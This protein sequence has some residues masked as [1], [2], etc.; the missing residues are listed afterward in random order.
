MLLK[1][2]AKHNQIMSLKVK[3]EMRKGLIKQRTI[4]YIKN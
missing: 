3:L 1:K 2:L 4:K